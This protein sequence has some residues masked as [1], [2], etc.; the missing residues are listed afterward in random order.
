[1]FFDSPAFGIL[2]TIIAYQIGLH[3]KQKTKSDLANPLLLA[4][5]IIIVFLML[6]HIPYE[7]Y[8]IG[9][10]FIHFFLSPLTVALGLMLYRQRHII[11][12]YFLSLMISISTG[13]IT[14]YFILKQL[15]TWFGLADDILYSTYPKSITTP[16]AISLSQIIGGHSSITVIMVMLTG[17]TGAFI[18]PYII[19]VFPFL[20]PIAVG[21]GI[22]TS[23]H[24]VGT[25][26]ALEIGETEGALSGTA[27]G[28]CGILTVLFVPI[29][30]K[31]F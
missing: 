14:S 23:A 11:K 26:K 17:I 18:A 16:M 4:M 27:I 29:L 2:I 25:S 12:K 6:A 8:K 13:I 7:Q 15:G 24:A 5:I 20:N 10:D 28:L 9:G 3:I 22:G 21:I 19:K 30:V 1:M 31:L